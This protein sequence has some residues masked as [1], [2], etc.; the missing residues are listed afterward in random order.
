LPNPFLFQEQEIP[1][2]KTGSDVSIPGVPDSDLIDF[3]LVPESFNSPT[4]AS[5]IFLP[6]AKFPHLRTFSSL[7]L[8]R[9]ELK[10]IPRRKQPFEVPNEIKELVGNIVARLRN[11]LVSMPVRAHLGDRDLVSSLR[12]IHMV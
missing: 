6:L 3:E 12:N 10:S 9:L 7:C 4:G 2:V 1:D 8:N 5:F 11:L